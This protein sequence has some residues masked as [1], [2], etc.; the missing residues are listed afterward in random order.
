MPIYPLSHNAGFVQHA[1]LT[2]RNH[3]S[4]RN[5]TLPV[6]KVRQQKCFLKKDVLIL[7]YQIKALQVV[8]AGFIRTDR[9]TGASET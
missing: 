7:G 9:S 5:I 3:Q 6:I 4:S 8:K 2:P 1:P